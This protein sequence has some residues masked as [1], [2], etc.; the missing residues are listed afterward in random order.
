MIRRRLHPA[1]TPAPVP[2]VL[3]LLLAVPLAV[4][5]AAAWAK[6]DGLD[7]LNRKMEREQDRKA[8]LDR[9]ARALAE[10][11]RAAKDELLRTAAA[12]QD[13][14][15][16]ATR[17]EG[18]IA[19]LAREQDRLLS[20]L[21]ERRRQAAGV[22]DALQRLAR[23]PPEALFLR[24][25]SAA[26]TVRGAILLRA[27]V[28]RIERRVRSLRVDLDALRDTRHAADERR[29]E[30]AAALARLAG[31][32]TAL[33]DLMRRKDA[34]AARADSR[35]QAAE[36]RLAAL[37]RQAGSLRDLMDGLA[38]ERNIRKP[39]RKPDPDV[40]PDTA[41]GAGAAEPP[42]PRESVAKAPVGGTP[43]SQARGRLAMPVTGPVVS[44][45]GQSTGQGQTAKGLTIRA[46]GG[47]TVVAPYD[48]QVVF[49]GPFRG[50]GR[51]L[52][53]EHGEGYHSLLAGMS[54]IDGVIGQWVL[55]GEPV[56]EMDGSGGE[57]PVLY[58]ELRRN[59][60]P[61]NPLP[62]LAA[63]K[64]KASG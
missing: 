33:D 22:L 39:Q 43:I 51:L 46:R 40:A 11:A 48:G 19:D 23:H 15:Q 21:G 10:D 59:G 14:E 63:R 4:A 36:R 6:T 7:A 41:P 37:S 34:A 9:Q 2:W 58:V 49:A 20:R 26:D 8:A 12:V 45:Y 30:L 18:L 44:V 47:A 42:V 31:R 57:K 1:V 3:A 25:G 17:I 35:R 27:S 24:P 28:P 61:I 5:P 62:W 38:A 32:R 29:Q 56:G 50:Y 53:I 52:I 13:L 54:R 60:R 64:D 16:E 55:A